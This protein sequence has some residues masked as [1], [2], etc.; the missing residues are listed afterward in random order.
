MKHKCFVGLVVKIKY[1]KQIFRSERI[2][3]KTECFLIKVYRWIMS[4][5]AFLVHDGV[6]G[7]KCG[8][9]GGAVSRKSQKAVYVCRVC[10]KF[11]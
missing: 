3:Q 10:L 5:E 1:H 2:V 8:G 4:L 6:L 7:N 9:G 11:Q